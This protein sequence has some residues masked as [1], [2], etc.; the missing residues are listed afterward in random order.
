MHILLRSVGIQVWDADKFPVRPFAVHV[1]K[2]RYRLRE[3]LLCRVEQIRKESTTSDETAQ[4]KYG[5]PVGCA[6]MQRN[7][8]ALQSIDYCDDYLIDHVR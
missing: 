5:G 6:S 2:V 3:N 8:T 1:I 7:A 4:L